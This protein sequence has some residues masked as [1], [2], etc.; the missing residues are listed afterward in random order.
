MV[1][2]KP[3]GLLA[4]KGEAAPA[5]VKAA[6]NDPALAWGGERERA[7]MNWDDT[8]AAGLTPLPTPAVRKKAAPKAAPSPQ[9]SRLPRARHAFTARLPMPLY[10]RLKEEAARTGR[11]MTHL[12]AE[13][14]GQA[15]R[16]APDD[17]S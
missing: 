12:V 6:F 9:A 11:P 1:A 2:L 3:S 17:H 7:P 13:A 4:R 14:L 16:D 5:L 10:R 8:P 15:L